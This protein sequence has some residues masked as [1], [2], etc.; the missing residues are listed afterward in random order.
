LSF[1]SHLFYCQSIQPNRLNTSPF[2]N[3]N[4]LY[5]IGYSCSALTLSSAAVRAGGD[6]LSSTP[7]KIFGR[8]FKYVTH[9]HNND[10]NNNTSYGIYIRRHS[11][12]PLAPPRLY[13]NQ[14]DHPPPSLIHTNQ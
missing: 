9:N 2:N 12:I 7:S 5:Q 4:G 3:R 13:Y 10:N 6:A 14:R 1:F 11:S 8:F